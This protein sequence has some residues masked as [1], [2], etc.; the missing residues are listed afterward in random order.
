LASIVSVALF[1][2]PGITAEE[3]LFAGSPPPAITIEQDQIEAFLA[4]YAAPQDKLDVVV[5]GA[6]QLSLFEIEAVARVL[7][8]RR[9]HHDTTVIVATLPVN[10][11]STYRKGLTSRFDDTSVDF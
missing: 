3:A 6:P 2:M 10:K 9:V 4:R 1:H 8:G 5:F 7:D 11:Q